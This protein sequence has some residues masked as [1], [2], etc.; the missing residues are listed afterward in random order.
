MVFLFFVIV[1][2]VVQLHI[3]NNDDHVHAYIFMCGSL[4]LH[5]FSQLQLC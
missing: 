4:I 2:V 3:W 5:V 1:D